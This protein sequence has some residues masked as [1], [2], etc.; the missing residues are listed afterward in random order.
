MEITSMAPVVEGFKIYLVL[1]QLHKISSPIHTRISERAQLTPY[2]LAVRHGMTDLSYGELDLRSNIIAHHLLSRG[3]RKEDCIGVHLQESILIPVVILGILKAGATYVPLSAELP[4]NRINRIIDD[5]SIRLVF[6]D[7]GKSSAFTTGHCPVQELDTELRLLSEHN[8][9]LPSVRTEHED[10]AYIIYTS[11]STGDPKGVIVSHG[12]MTNYLDWYLEDLHLQSGA[13]LPLT[14]SISF[15]AGVTQLFSAL[16]LGETL[17]IID[18]STVRQPALLLE[19]YRQ[20]PDHALYCVPTLWEE[21]M[22]YAE[23]HA[24]LPLVPPACLYLSG[25]SLPRS[26]VDRSFRYWPDIRIWNLYGPT[27]ATANVS[28]YKVEKDREIYLGKPIRGARLVLLDERLQRVP[29]GEEGFIYVTSQALAR[30]YRNKPELSRRAF[31]TDHN[32]EGFEGCTLYN[33]GDIGKFTADNELLFLGRKDQQVKIRGHRIELSEVEKYIQSVAGVRQAACKV[34]A[35]SSG[36]DRIHAF[37]VSS[38]GARLSVN[39]LREELLQQLPG[40]MI[41]EVFH[42]LEAMPKL[43]NGKINRQQ[44][45]AATGGTARPGLSYAYVAPATDEERLLLDI[46]AEVLDVPDPGMQDDFFDLGGHSLK[47][48]RLANSIRHRMDREVPIQ[49]LWEHTTPAAQVKLLADLATPAAATDTIARQTIPRKS[50]PLS[51]HQLG[52]WFT[53]QSRPGLTAYNMLFT[54]RLSGN[55]TPERVNDVLTQLLE[56]H[57]I[58]RSGFR[59]ESMNPVRFIRDAVPAQVAFTD[60]STQGTDDQAAFE[61]SLCDRLFQQTPDLAE[62]PLISFHLLRHNTTEH[63]LLVYV[64]HIIF[65]GVSI[66]LFSHEFAALWNGR[67]LSADMPSY[68]DYAQWEKKNYFDEKL[69]LSLAFWKQ[70][71]EGGN[72]FLNLPTDRPRPKVQEGKGSNR[73]LLIDTA[74]LK[75]LEQFN[76]R[77]KST[78]FIVLLSVFQVLLHR[79]TREQDLF[80]GIPFANRTLADTR[81]ILGFFVNTVVYRTHCAPELPFRELMHNIRAY[82][83]QALEHQSYPF[84]RLVEQLNPERSVSYHPL[85]QVMFAYHDKLPTHTTD[86]G[87]YIRTDEV[88]NPGCKF[89]LE[90][91]AQEHENHIAVRF[92]YDTALFDAATIDRMTEQFRYLL[93]QALAQPGAQVGSYQL[94]DDIQLRQ[95]LACWN[96]TAYPIA[97]GSLHERF[98][99]QA[100]ATPD[101]IA[102]STTKGTMSYGELNETSNRIAHAL[103]A[104]GVRPDEPVGIMAS[105]SPLLVAGILGILKAGAAYLPIDPQIP[106]ERLQYTI[107]NSRLRLLLAQQEAA[108]LNAAGVDI[109]PLDTDSWYA[110]HPS[111]NPVLVNT[112]GHLAYVIYTSGSTGQPKGVMIEHRAAMNRIAW[113]QRSFPLDAS[114]VILQKTTVTFDVSVWEL[115]WWFFAGASVHLPEP[116]AEKNP[117]S[118][119]TAITTQQVSTLHFVPSMLSTFLEYVQENRIP[120]DAFASLKR[121]FTS[122][123]ALEKHHVDRFYRLIAAGNDT[124]LINLYGPTEATVDVSYFDCAD[125]DQYPRVPIGRPID[126]TQLYILDSEGN[127]LPEKVPGE[128]CIGG[129]GLARGYLNNTALTEERFFKSTFGRLYRSGDL[130][131]L[132]PDGN[133]E[134]LGRTD[135]QVKVRGFRI[136]LGEIENSINRHPDVETSAALVRKVGYEDIRLV[137]Y[138]VPRN[139][140]SKIDLKAHLRAFLP[141]YMIPSAFVPV[142]SLPLL[143]SGKLDTKALPEPFE[144]QQKVIGQRSYNNEYERRLAAVW[145]QVLRHDAFDTEDNFYDVGG[146]SLLLVKMKLSLDTEFNTNIPLVDLFQYPTIRSLAEVIA[147]R[148]RLDQR[149][150]IA[151]RA[152]LQRAASSLKRPKP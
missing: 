51:M 125:A 120:A 105:R 12:S 150:G 102:L 61:A 151:D 107:G 67:Q 65:D 10:A 5:A 95:K 93:D 60:L 32:I 149:A 140:K 73:L 124:R 89:D 114:D 14:S 146:H 40:Y 121:V 141:D 96:D 27:E 33:T 119:I 142:E 100:A 59:I 72:Y 50:V 148:T 15:A 123:E 71:L 76:R 17:H 18:R 35:D 97:E 9:A 104:K 52:L 136:E 101:R 144:G 4:E 39:V 143:S 74:R 86:D 109:L 137:A 83:A 122:G 49:A 80:T 103:R 75:E 8:T 128:L 56:R 98:E 13:G 16:L 88:Q 29:Q 84:S 63:K 145:S 41:P 77:E 2:A 127:P 126:N 135:H 85:F 20:H 139:G 70:Q 117:E 152:R 69:S 108:D 118:L 132:L 58:L 99:H 147:S 36:A 64:H 66:A 134:Y 55:A 82:T 111:E 19:W 22:N 87:L 23:S 133:I 92:H 26:L 21:V 37:V 45:D 28:Y 129:A 130:A 131:R 138:F 106:A 53:L 110:M 7:E 44:L 81:S 116:G 113:M 112:P 115:F 91:E 24:D 11:G 78:S 34:M 1:S 30:E 25:E 57:D 46:W 48:V 90:V 42:F 31:I 79:Y 3:I 54:L 94:E 43:G 62:D 68:G 47:M 6:T 38:E